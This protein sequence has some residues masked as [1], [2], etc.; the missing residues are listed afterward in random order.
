MFCRPT[1]P[2]FLVMSVEINNFFA[3]LV[4]GIDT[5]NWRVVMRGHIRT[6]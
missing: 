1:V 2:L 3:L 4:Y 5:T 6:L